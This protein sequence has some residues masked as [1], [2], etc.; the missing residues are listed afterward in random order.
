M[1]PSD[2]N[3]LVVPV[4]VAG[5]TG[6]TQAARQAAWMTAPGSTCKEDIWPGP[7]SQKQQQALSSHCGAMP[8][9]FYTSTGFI[10]VGP[11]GW[12]DPLGARQGPRSRVEPSPGPMDNVVAWVQAV[13]GC[14]GSE[15]QEFMAGSARCPPHCWGTGH[16]VAFPTDHRHGW[17]LA[18][19]FR[20]CAGND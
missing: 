5:R 2:F 20:R 4:S 15:T 19:L 12:R 9:E 18:G 8:K 3:F 1:S 14:G 7:L 10:V 16:L 6:H 13:A 11:S 17:D